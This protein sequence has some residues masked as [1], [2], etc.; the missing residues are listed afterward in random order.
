MPN[1]HRLKGRTIW[2]V[3]GG[4]GGGWGIFETQ[5]FFF[6]YQIPCINS[7]SIGLKHMLRLTAAWL[8]QLGERRSAGEG[9][10]GGGGV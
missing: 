2:K 8:A 3:M 6:R 7:V 10:E 5:E 1:A 9:E 4:G